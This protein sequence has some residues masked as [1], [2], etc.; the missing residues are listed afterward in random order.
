MTY[1][2][3]PNNVNQTIIDST[4][5]TIGDGGTK[6]DSTDNGFNMSKAASLATP[7]KFSVTMDF[8]WLVK[9]EYGRSEF[10]RFCTW[11][12]TV[13][14][15]GVHPFFFGSITKFNINGSMEECAYKITSALNASK[16][17]YSMRV[18]M[19]WE[20]VYSGII[21]IPSGTPTVDHINAYN[22]RIEV[23][24][25]YA[26]DTTP[27]TSDHYFSYGAINAS[28]IGDFVRMQTPTKVKMSDNVATYFLPK[29]TTPGNYRVIIDSDLTKYSIMEVS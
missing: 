28:S 22:G 11:F 6:T 3:W 2:G 19:T 29:I 1:V 23:Y 16:S 24:F 21:E 20:E 26:P 18:T 15:K 17:G 13:H 9:D 25:T 14:Q 7:D 27:L 5:L 8:D 4:S 12:K 10:D